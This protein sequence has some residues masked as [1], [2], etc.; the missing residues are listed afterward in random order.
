MFKH[1]FILRH[2]K[3]GFILKSELIYAR[4][5]SKY[6]R[7]VCCDTALDVGVLVSLVV[8]YRERSVLPHYV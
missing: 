5:H 2:K 8:N 3:L 7:F 4:A 6:N 1:P